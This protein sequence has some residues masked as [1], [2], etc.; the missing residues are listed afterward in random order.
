MISHEDAKKHVMYYMG[1]RL[2][3]NL[4]SRD[5]SDLKL[6]YVSTFKFHVDIQDP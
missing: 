2:H 3:T 4:L 1:V 5:A 6:P